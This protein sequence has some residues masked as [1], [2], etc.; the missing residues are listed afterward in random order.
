MTLLA[1]CGDANTNFLTRE[2]ELRTAISQLR[3][4]IGAH[5]RV[6]KIEVDADVVAI[7][8]RLRDTPESSSKSNTGW[9][10]YDFDGRALD[11]SAP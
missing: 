4:A 7:E 6:L 1:A 8:V 2:A 3:S 10:V 5:P 11:F 9:I